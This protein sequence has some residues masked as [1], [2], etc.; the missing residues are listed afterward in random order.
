MAI[1]FLLTQDGDIDIT[2]NTM[3]LTQNIETSSRQQIL[4]TLRTYL[5][6]WVYNI[7]AGIPYLANDN[8]PIQ[9]LGKSSQ[10]LVD[11]YL[12]Q[13]I[14]ER[15]NVTEILAYSSNF[16]KR[17]RV[18]TVSFEALTNSGEVISVVDAPIA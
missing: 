9:L 12:R 17:S 10:S 16:D 8:N 13:A 6:E 4:I 2:N 15:E 18:S 3:T 7:S 11:F 1:D 14:L 5:G